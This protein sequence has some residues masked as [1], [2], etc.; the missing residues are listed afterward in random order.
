[1]RSIRKQIDTSVGEVQELASKVSL[2]DHANEDREL[3]GSIA[4]G[5]AEA[6]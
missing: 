6:E 5:Q 1:M 4:G 2:H 3:D